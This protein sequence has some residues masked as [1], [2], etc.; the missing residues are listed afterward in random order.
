MDY[1]EHLYEEPCEVTKA[2]K[3]FGILAT[4][5]FVMSVVLL[6]IMPNGEEKLSFLYSCLLF[7]LCVSYV[8]LYNAAWRFHK[9]IS[10][11]HYRNS[12]SLEPSDF[13]LKLRKIF[14]YVSFFTGVFVIIFYVYSY[15]SGILNIIKALLG[16]R[17]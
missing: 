8:F 13:S 12:D 10:A 4:L 5:G 7:V 14:I 6:I 11:L 16:G 17:R 1:Q 9:R 15:E 3:V 2:D